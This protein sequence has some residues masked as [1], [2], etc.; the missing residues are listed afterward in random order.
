MLFVIL[1]YLVMAA[2]VHGCVNASLCGM[3]GE[4]FVRIRFA[5]FNL[6]WHTDLINHPK[7]TDDSAA[8]IL[9]L[10]KKRRAER[11]AHG[12]RRRR[13]AEKQLFRCAK[14][15][16][17]SV[18]GRIGLGEAWNTALAAGG[19]SAAV[20]S[21]LSALHIPSRPQVRIV[22]DYFHTGACLHLRCIFSVTAGD[23]IL[24]TI[25]TVVKHA[26]RKE[27]IHAAASH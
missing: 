27:R 8:E 13:N 23:V 19:L 7:G 6:I 15:S 17:F 11:H 18:A 21:A 12:R 14:M 4:A 9:T 20:V 3:Q 1:L 26:A 25:S 5:G 10:L 22:P 24:K 16:S 2:P